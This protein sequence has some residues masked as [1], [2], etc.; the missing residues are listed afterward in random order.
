MRTGLFNY[1][2]KIM[3]RTIQFAIFALSLIFVLACTKVTE[4]K[5]QEKKQT[6]I[7]AFFADNQNKT[8]LVDAGTKVYWEPSDEVKL[9]Y[10]TSGGRFTTAITTTAIV[11]DFS[12]DLNLT[13]SYHEGFAG[14]TPMFG[15]Y[16]YREDATSDG[17]TVTTT[18]PS[19][20]TGKAGSFAQGMNISL[21]KA[22]S[23]SMGFYN[24]CGGVRFSLT[25]E[26]VRNIVFK[27]QKGESLAG[28]IKVGFEGIVPDIQ[29]ISESRSS[30]TLTAPSGG[31]FETGKWYYI[32]AIPGTLS[33]GY[34]MRFNTDAGYAELTSSKS[35][36]IKRSI[37]GSLENVDNGLK[38]E[39]TLDVKLSDVTRIT[40]ASAGRGANIY[41]V[42]SIVTCKDG[43]LLA[44]SELRYNSWLDKSYTDIVYWKST[45]CGKTWSTAKKLTSSIN[46]GS[47]AFMDP[48]PVVDDSTGEIFLF[49][50]RWLKLNTD[51][52]NNKA[53]LIR[54]TDNGKTFGTPVDISSYTIFSNTYSSGFGPGHGIC[55]KTGKY[56]GR[57]VVITRQYTGTTS[58]GYTIYSDDHGATWS[59]SNVMTYAGEAQVAE[60]AV[61][62][63]YANLRRGTERYSFTSTTGAKSWSTATLE[64]ELPQFEKGCEA[65]VLGL[66]N[67][68]LFYCGPAG[69]STIEGYDNRYN[70]TLFRSSNAGA[71]WTKK[72]IL[73]EKASG[74]SDMTQIS[75]GRIIL[76]YE[77]GPYKGFTKL[78][79]DRPA[80]WMRL[81]ILTI[82]AKICEDRYWFR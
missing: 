41:R 12:G 9:F 71:D 48:T 29:D 36:T 55:I 17:K 69:S 40:L 43:S 75:D 77:A 37:F 61:N 57:L 4:Q 7:T 14:S 49:C 46:D 22:E 30:I 24:I 64:T 33:N 1:I 65:S 32:A 21:G 59:R 73:S 50:T 67:N 52:T 42:P 79:G 72:V 10:K 54:S 16:P 28:R 38:Y 81:D 62:Y 19:Q 25:H 78:E 11:A 51:A 5:V 34:K 66:C 47:Y 26:G 6:T 63:L 18:L 27:S 15:L 2:E 39:D 76:I 31:T 44:F 80:G 20:Q 60:P 3:K 58:K 13:A 23:M 45:D 8:T 35:V 68:I 56:K 82:P 74:Y 70:L 53:F